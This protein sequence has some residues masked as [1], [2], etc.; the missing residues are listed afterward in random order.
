MGGG[1]LNVS[2]ALTLTNDVL[3]NNEALGNSINGTLGEG[4]AIANRNGGTLVVTG[5]LFTGN[6]AVGSDSGGQARGGAIYN[7][8]ATI[9]VAGSAFANP[10]EGPTPLEMQK[11]SLDD[12]EAA[13][14]RLDDVRARKPE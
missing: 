10:T 8:G 13:R 5:C 4:G 2:S 7:A 9:S 14:L 3:A 12:V 1:I 11:E 6:R